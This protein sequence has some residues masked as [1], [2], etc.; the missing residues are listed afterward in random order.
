MTFFGGPLGS[1]VLHSKV[2]LFERLR[3]EP[4]SL[5]VVGS[6][7][8]FYAHFGYGV[9]STDPGAAPS[10][11]I[12]DVSD[13]FAALPRRSAEEGREGPVTVESYT[14]E[15]GH[16]GPRKATIT[17]LTD[18]GVRVFARSEDAAL[19]NALLADEDLGGRHARVANGLIEVA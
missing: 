5:G 12:E 3:A 15:V 16:E 4:G 8:G 2:S 14:V 9:Y 13:A 7:G 11:Q 6:L 1:Y 10:P 17:A 19:M 18:D